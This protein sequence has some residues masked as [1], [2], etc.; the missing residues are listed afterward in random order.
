MDSVA[1]EIGNAGE[2]RKMK[3]KLVKANYNIRQFIIAGFCGFGNLC[4]KLQ[5]LGQI[6]QYDYACVVL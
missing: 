6:L 2:K 1:I 5:R 4:Y 3:E